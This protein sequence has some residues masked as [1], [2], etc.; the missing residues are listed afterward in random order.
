MQKYSPLGKKLMT[1]RVGEQPENDSPFNGATDIA[2]GPSGHLFIADGYGNSGILEYTA[3]G[4]RIKQWGKP[5]VGLASS[6]YHMRSRLT[7]EARST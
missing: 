6:I 1:V 7:R 5:G 2:F 3:D 4:K